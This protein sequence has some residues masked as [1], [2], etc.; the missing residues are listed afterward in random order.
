MQQNFCHWIIL[1][2]YLLLILVYSERSVIT[3]RYHKNV[4]WRRK[5]IFL[6]KNNLHDMT[7][8]CH[9]D[10]DL[11][12]RL[13]V[14][15]IHQYIKFPLVPSRERGCPG[16]F[17][18]VPGPRSGGRDPD[19]ESF[20]V[21]WDLRGIP[22]KLWFQRAVGS[23]QLFFVFICSFHLGPLVD[24]LQPI[25]NYPQFYFEGKKNFDWENCRFFRICKNFPKILAWWV[26][27]LMLYVRWVIR[28]PL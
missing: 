11:Q 9:S 22:T 14:S 28:T 27:H 1:E 26:M 21:T 13:G 25:K 3:R 4:I 16:I 8:N 10:N 5:Q 23:W 15:L 17:W 12:I 24:G 18:T 7:A 6:V 2:N 20:E 19:L